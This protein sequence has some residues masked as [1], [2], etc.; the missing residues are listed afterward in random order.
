MLTI[1]ENRFQALE[2]STRGCWLWDWHLLHM[3]G[4]EQVGY[5]RE[6]EA[7]TGSTGHYIGLDLRT[8]R[9]PLIAMMGSN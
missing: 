8:N 4:L 1:G 7:A 3:E 5:L 9:T 6:T 2:E